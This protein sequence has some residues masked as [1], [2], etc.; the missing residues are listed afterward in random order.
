MGDKMELVPE[1]FT[2][3]DRAR[4]PLFKQKCTKCHAM[5]RPIAALRTGITPVTGGKFDEDGIKK[6]VVKMMRK[7]KSGID[8]DDAKELILF[9]R[10]ARHIAEGKPQE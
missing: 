1:Q 10:D 5:S 8:K 7:P 3:D 9:L 6:Y 4:Y 2:S